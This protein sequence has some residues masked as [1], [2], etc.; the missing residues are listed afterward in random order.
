MVKRIAEQ[1]HWYRDEY[2][3]SDGWK[4]RREVAIVRAGRKCQLCGAM[5]DSFQV[6]HNSYERLGHELPSDLIVL[7]GECHK[8]FHA[9]RELSRDEQQQRW[10]EERERHEQALAALKMR[11]IQVLYDAPQGMRF[12]EWTTAVIPYEYHVTTNAR[13]GERMEYRTQ[14]GLNTLIALLKHGYLPSQHKFVTKYASTR[15]GQRVNLYYLTREG[16][17]WYEQQREIAS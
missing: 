13:T 10:A 16:R 7:C 12:T 9:E 11:A 15:N 4:R 3:N 6:H 5:P 17:R 14:P 1:P 2:L 8:R